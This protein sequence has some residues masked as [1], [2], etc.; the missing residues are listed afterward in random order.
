LRAMRPRRF[1]AVS[2]RPTGRSSFVTFEEPEREPEGE[3]LAIAGRGFAPGQDIILRCREFERLQ[4]RVRADTKGQFSTTL[5]LPDSF[6]HGTFMFEAHG[7]AG[8]LTAS[9][10]D[11]PYSTRLSKRGIVS[12]IGT[13]PAVTPATNLQRSAR[14]ELLCL[15]RRPIYRHNYVT[16]TTNKK[17][18]HRCRPLDM[19]SRGCNRIRLHVHAP[20]R[21]ERK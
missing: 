14:Y 18:P 6:P 3:R 10:F 1:R 5:P 7:A 17:G 21:L 9:E 2:R 12:S 20:P 19:G 15:V 16:T 13:R 4:T 8:K 11:K